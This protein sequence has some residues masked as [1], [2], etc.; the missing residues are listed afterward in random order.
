MKKAQDK[1]RKEDPDWNSRRQRK[2]RAENPDKFNFLM[3]KTYFKKLSPEDREKL[4]RE[5]VE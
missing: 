1:K 5:A 3:A 4:V 2:W